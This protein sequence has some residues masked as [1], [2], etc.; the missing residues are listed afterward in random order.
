VDPAQRG[1]ARV[2]LIVHPDQDQPRIAGPG[3]HHL[4][5]AHARIPGPDRHPRVRAD[6]PQTVSI[7]SPTDG[8]NADAYATVEWAVAEQSA[9][10]IRILHA[11]ADTVYHDSGRIL[12]ATSR[13]YRAPFAPD[14]AVRRVEVRTW[15]S[16]GL[17]SEP[18]TH[19][20][21]VVY[22]PPAGPVVSVTANPPEGRIRIGVG[23]H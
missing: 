17:P 15:S 13:S 9:Y 3:D 12:D 19:S 4:G 7:D 11:T 5:K 23:D 6:S 20:V 2:G 18:V 21:N 8:A 22:V 14:G 10:Q 16:K 1:G